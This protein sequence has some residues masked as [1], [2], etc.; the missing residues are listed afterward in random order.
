MSLR[1]LEYIAAVARLKHFANAAKECHVSQPTLSMQIKKFEELI[2]VPVF[3]RNLNKVM[4][5]EAGYELVEKAKNILILQKEMFE[6]A[7]QFKNPF[8]GTIKIGA[9]P[10]LAPYLF[11]KIIPD[12]SGKYNDLKLFLIEEKTEV[13]FSQLKEGLIDGAFL[14]PS[15]ELQDNDL[16]S[17]YLFSDPFKLAVSEKHPLARRKSISAA[18]LLNLKLLLLDEG[19]CLRDQALPLCS[20]ESGDEK[21]NFRATSLETLRQM[22]AAD[23]GIT[24]M[25]LI[26]ITNLDKGIKY[27]PVKGQNMKREIHLFYRKSS[28]KKTLLNKIAGITINNFQ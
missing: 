21:E 1:T 11:P 7:E 27:L 25:P 9:F 8:A 18:E 16:C 15:E 12:I 19:H 26:A 5:T 23:M 10:T 6:I 22:I 2:G 14:A 17:P 20:I 13:L 24:L 3:E 28:P 4:L